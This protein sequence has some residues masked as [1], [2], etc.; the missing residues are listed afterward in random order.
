MAKIKA[1]FTL[2]NLRQGEGLFTVRLPSRSVVR[3]VGSTAKILSRGGSPSRPQVVVRVDTTKDG[4]ASFELVCERS[5]DTSSEGPIDVGGFSIDEVP[6]QRQWGQV[7]VFTDEDWTVE[8]EPQSGNRQVDASAAL[9]QEGFVAAF[10]FD[11]QP[12]TCIADGHM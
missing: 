8:W 11:S 4:H 3:S 12:R 2:T 10:A 7:S 9:S 6:L 5:I 1:E